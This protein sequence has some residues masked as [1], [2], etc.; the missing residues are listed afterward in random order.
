LQLY[1]VRRELETDFA[2]TLDKVAALGFR[3]VEFASYFKHSP[4]EVKSI[5]AHYQLSS[6]S[7]HISTA[8]LRGNLQ[9]EIE[10]AQT[11]GHQYLVCGYLPAQ[12]RGTV[13]DYKR[14]VELLNRA[15]ERLKKA[16]IQFGY[17][18]HDFEFAT[19]VGGEGKLPY[20]MI[21]AGTDPELVKMEL[22]LYWIIKA[23]Q[24]PLKYFSAYQGRFPLIHVKDMD[25]TPRHFFTE[26]GQGTIDFKKIFAGAR[27][28]GVQHYFVEQDETPA[29][30]FSSIK[31]SVDYLKRLE[32]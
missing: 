32:F 19:I 27:K 20:E 28:A 17:H 6:P 30:P 3:E 1:T 24:D 16:G 5:L 13:D 12:E 10:A 4:Q 21:L 9:E 8:A 14:L 26:V 18:N 11:I 2:G 31:L 29:S 7:A 25:A 22:D 15:G 23:G